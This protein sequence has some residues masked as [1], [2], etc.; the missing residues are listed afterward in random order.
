MATVKALTSRGHKVIGTFNT[1]QQAAESLK[2]N[3][4]NL[5]IFHVDLADYGSID[6]LIKQLGGIQL[7]GIVNSAGIFEDVDFDDF[8]IASLEKNFKVNAFAP[9][10]LVQNLKDN[11]QDGS[12][13]VNISSTDELVGSQAGMGYS[14]SKAAVSSLTRSLAMTLAPRKIRVNA[15]S[16]GWIG[17]GMRAPEELLE[18]AADYNPL[19]HRGSYEDVANLICYLLSDEAAYVNGTTIVADGGDLAKN[20]ILEKESEILS[21]EA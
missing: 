13:I 15:V 4:Q 12:A 8:D 19:K 2:N 17:D 1:D 20:Y 3:T 6:E 14:A 21:A 16:P 7:D 18:L 11:L 5:E 9:V 10:Y